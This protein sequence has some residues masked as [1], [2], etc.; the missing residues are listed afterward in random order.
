MAKAKRASN[1]HGHIRQRPDGKWEGQYVSPIDG[2]RKSVYGKTQREVRQKLTQVQSDIDANVFVAPDRMTVGEWL[3]R[4]IGD[5][6]NGVKES[7]RDSYRGHIEN[8]LKPA[9]G[10]VKLTSLTPDMCQSFVNSLKDKPGKG[11]KP[12]SAKTI[13]NIAGTLHEALRRAVKNRYIRFN[14]AADL[15]KPRIEKYEIQPLDLPD[16]KALMEVLGDDLYSVIVKMDMFCGMREGEILGLQ[17]SRIDFD[18]GTIRIDLQLCRPRKKG[19]VYKLSS[20]KTDRVRVIRP[21]PFVMQLLKQRRQRQLE[22][23]LQVGSLWNDHGFPDLV[24]TYPDGKYLC[25]TVVLRHLRKCLKMAGLPEHRFHDLRDTFA[26]TS[27]AIG[28]D[29]KTVQGNLGHY[30]ASFT[31]NRYVGFTE[32]MRKASS[33]RMEGFITGLSQ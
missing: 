22:E 26:T 30:D 29:A 3:D 27:I 31:L 14:P 28:D 32:S 18:N 1:G 7:T 21:A 10:N 5:Y 23:R 17:W 24:F 16:I 25:Y 2:K 4:W 11:D 19:D 15:D 6:C 9:L 20:V 13:K 8:H 33:N 12:M